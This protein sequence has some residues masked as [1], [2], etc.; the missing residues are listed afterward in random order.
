[1]PTATVRLE[2]GEPE[3]PEEHVL[4]KVGTGPVDAVYRAIDEVAARLCGDTAA[5]D[6][7]EYAIQSVTSGIDALGEVRVRIRPKDPRAR[8]VPE[9]GEQARVFHGHGTD[10]DIVV[11]SAKAYLSAVNRVLAAQ[12]A[13]EDRAERGA[14]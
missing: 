11:A 13:A 12:A 2:T 1:M 6:L 7:L 5:V 9:G 3:A 8:L 4:A 10:T 14:A